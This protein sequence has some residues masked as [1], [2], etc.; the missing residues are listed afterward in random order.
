MSVKFKFTSEPSSWNLMR[1]CSQLSNHYP[2]LSK[3]DISLINRLAF[4]EDK[5]GAYYRKEEY[6]HIKALYEAVVEA[7]HKPSKTEA[8]SSL[9]ESIKAHY[10]KRP[11][12]AK[13]SETSL[14]EDLEP[15]EMRDVISDLYKEKQLNMRLLACVLNSV[16]TQHR[17]VFLFSKRI[18][19]D[20]V[21]NDKNLKRKAFNGDEYANFM[22]N[23][24]GTYIERITDA[25]EERR[26]T[27]YRLSHKGILQILLGVISMKILKSQEEQCLN[28]FNSY[29][30]SSRETSQKTSRD[31]N[32]SD[33]TSS[34]SKRTAATAAGIV[35]K[36]LS[37]KETS[38]SY[39]ASKRTTPNS[40]SIPE[41]KVKSSRWYQHYLKSSI[42]E[43]TFNSLPEI[44]RQSLFD[45]TIS[46]EQIDRA[47]AK[48]RFLA[49]LIAFRS[50]QS[51]QV[52]VDLDSLDF[53]L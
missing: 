45:Q 22:V 35:S 25:C 52:E 17:G 24:E 23:T 53:G 37:S 42:N 21:K 6:E 44:T 51:P 38:N 27:V 15:S 30:K 29:G 14:I 3:E 49:G 33:M 36:N 31:K 12:Q 4:T 43:D 28:I 1:F 8:T 48:D 11:D 13:L 10:K 7:K 26:A 9:L 39:P 50:S 18:L 47:E 40:V 16:F 20:L 41:W 5:T 32:R 19:E 46:L 2:S 34:A